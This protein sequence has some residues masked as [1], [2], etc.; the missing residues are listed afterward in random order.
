MDMTKDIREIAELLLSDDYKDRF[1][2]EYWLV[3]TKHSKLET[4]LDD[5]YNNRLDFELTCPSNKLLEQAACMRGYWECLRERAE[6]E[7]IDLYE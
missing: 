5:Y 7:G 3:A 2:G 6:I 1:K 4:L